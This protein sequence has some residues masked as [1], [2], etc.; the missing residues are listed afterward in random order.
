MFVK[1]PHEPAGAQLKVTPEF[2]ESLDTVTAMS[3]VALRP[4]EVG[5]V[6]EKATEMAGVGGGGGGVL[7]PPPPQAI[8]VKERQTRMNRGANGRF[9]AS[10]RENKF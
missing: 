8:K 4:S 10:P 3:A 7:L 6:V 1:L 9:I 5:G 2:E